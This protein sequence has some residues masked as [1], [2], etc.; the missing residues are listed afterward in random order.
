[1]MTQAWHLVQGSK[2][3]GPYTIEELYQQ[4]QLDPKQ[5]LW[6]ASLREDMS[7]EED[8]FKGLQR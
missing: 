5:R 1:M 8:D 4:G 2:K 6:H 3:T 7:V